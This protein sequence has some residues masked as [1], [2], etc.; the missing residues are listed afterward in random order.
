VL[1]VGCQRLLSIYLF[2][3]ISNASVYMLRAAIYSACNLI[4]V[5]VTKYRIHCYTLRTS[6]LATPP[7]PLFAFVGIGLYPLSPPCGRPMVDA[8]ARL[9]NVIECADGT[10]NSNHSPPPT[11]VFH[12]ISSV[13]SGQ[14]KPSLGDW[15]TL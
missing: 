4:T 2:A 1:A 10:L 8:K 14:S 9:R 12:Q 5:F 3:S 7:A 13:T 15:T 11:L 6:A